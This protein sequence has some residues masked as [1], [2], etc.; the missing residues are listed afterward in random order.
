MAVGG[1]V[2]LNTDNLIIAATLGADRVSDYALLARISTIL[3]P[4]ALVF[5]TSVAPVVSRLS[6][7]N[8]F[9]DLRRILGQQIRL[10]LLLVSL[11]GAIIAAVPEAVLTLWVGPGHFVG[12]PVLIVFL[13]MMTLE[14][15]HV[16]HAVL[17]M[18]TG[19]LPF[20][21]WALGS[22]ILNIAFSLLLVSHSGLL[23]VALG[24]MLA[25]LLTNNWFAPM[26][27]LRAFSISL[28]RYGREVI[29][30]AILTGGLLYGVA[31]L[32][33]VLVHDWSALASITVVTLA[34]TC[35]S[36]AVFTP[37]S[38]RLRRRLIRDV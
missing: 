4:L 6:A 28:M 37:I 8:R 35:A 10:A 26:Y 16:A 19:K 34:A 27:T 18:A 3:Q 24:T 32:A 36:L 13:V 25:Q 22:G 5:V 9:D 23:G 33:R 14:V 31:H 2:I 17:V 1:Y 7:E 12:Y 15:H 21:P 29:L 38:S 30:P 11:A 20:A